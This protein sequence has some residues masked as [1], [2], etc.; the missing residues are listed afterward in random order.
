MALTDLFHVGCHNPSIH[1]NKQTCRI[2][3]SHKAKQN[4]TRCV[5]TQ[6]YDFIQKMGTSWNFRDMKNIENK[7]FHFFQSSSQVLGEN[8][9]IAT[10]AEGF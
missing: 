3:K 5:C 4:K 8:I 6:I 10:V 7:S 2:Y 1:E 9:A